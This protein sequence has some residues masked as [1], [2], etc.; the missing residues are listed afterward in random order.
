MRPNSDVYVAALADTLRHLQRTESA[1]DTYAR[2]LDL[3]GQ[4]A[5]TRPLSVEEECHRAIYLARLGDRMAATAA[6]DAIAPGARSQDFAYARTIVA[7][8]EDRT[9]AASRHLKDAIQAGYP[10]MLIEMNPDFVH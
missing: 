3:V 7:M 5:Q 9:A 10:P 1:R 4:L 6:L 2:A 8:L